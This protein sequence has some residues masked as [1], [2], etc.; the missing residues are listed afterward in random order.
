MDFELISV[1][2]RD[3]VE[4]LQQQ[5]ERKPRYA[6]FVSTNLLVSWGN[7]VYQQID[8]SVFF[9]LAVNTKFPN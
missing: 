1:L 2:G 6:P 4:N 7:V 9:I 8:I 5:R 3:V